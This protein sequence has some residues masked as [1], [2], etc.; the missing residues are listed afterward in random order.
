MSSLTVEHFLGVYQIRKHLQESGISNPNDEI[1]E[2]T[3]DFVE[4]LSEMPL[5]DLV[6]I[7][8]NSF[9]D[10]RGN[11]IATILMNKE[12]SNHELGKG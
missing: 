10:A 9:Y 1:K 6:S 2:F 7:K 5:N 4:K 8:G 12:H 11:I 3:R